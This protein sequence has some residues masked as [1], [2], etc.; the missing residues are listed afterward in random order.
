MKISKQIK[1]YN[2]EFFYNKRI[3]C[4]EKEFYKLQDLFYNLEFTWIYPQKQCYS[5]KKLGLI[6]VKYEDAKEATIFFFSQKN[7]SEINYKDL[8]LE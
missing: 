7:G 3:L 6:L 5:N 4:N 1:S 2:K 8:K